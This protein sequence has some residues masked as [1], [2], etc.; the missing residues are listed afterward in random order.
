MS[1]ASSLTPRP[2]DDLGEVVA[3]EDVEGELSRRV[4]ALQA[5]A[6]HEP[7]LHARMSNLVVYCDRR[8]L[9]ETMAA[10]VPAVVIFHPAR[11]LLLVAELSDKGGELTAHVAVRSHEAGDGRKVY[12]E[13]VTLHASGPAVQRLPFAVRGLVIGD[14]PINLWWAAPLAPPL[15]GVLFHDLAEGAEQIVYDSLGWPV[16]AR[17]VAATAAW[18]AQVERGGATGRWCVASDLNWRRLKPWRR[19]LAQALDPA[20][21][22][23]VLDGINEVAVEHG[24]HAVVQAWE[25]VSWLAARLDWQVQAGRVQ[26]GVEITW[27]L[28]APH[29]KVRLRLRRLEEGPPMLRQVRITSVVD[30]KM[31]AL[32][33]TAEEEGKRLAVVPEGT[34]AAPR[35]VTVPP[36]PLAELVGRQLSDRERDPVFRSSMAVARVL[37]ES[38]LGHATA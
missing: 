2:A 10:V 23:G 22:P 19:L 27:Q 13:Q 4:R 9:A 5:S 20:S 11:V 21:A 30:S 6:A 36:Q 3:L 31:L 29:G 17:G 14:L 16:P 15:S 12:S 38:V 18:L 7:V 37:A 34:G 35:T 32:R 28:D 24:P 33:F 8:E 1:T 26:P 25:L